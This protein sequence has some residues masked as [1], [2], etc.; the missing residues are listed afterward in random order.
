MPDGSGAPL[1]FS[2]AC[3]QLPR[4]LRDAVADVCV[5]RRA[6]DARKKHD[7]PAIEGHPNPACRC[8]SVLRGETTPAGC[9]LFGK[10]CTPLHPVGACMVSGEGACSAYYQYGGE[11]R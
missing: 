9:P 8:G 3:A 5:L 2:A 6:V 7:M 11:L 10:V 1:V 4:E